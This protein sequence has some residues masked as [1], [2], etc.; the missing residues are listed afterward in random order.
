MSLKTITPSHR[1]LQQIAISIP[2]LYHQFDSNLA[3]RM[4]LGGWLELDHLLIQLRES[5]SVRLRV[6]YNVPLW[7]DGTWTR[8]CIENLLP[9]AT[10]RGIVDLVEGCEW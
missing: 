6:L 9:E 7:T 3:D 5:R 10:K 4:D 8:G 1:D 2:G